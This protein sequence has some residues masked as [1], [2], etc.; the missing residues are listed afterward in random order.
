MSAFQARYEG[1]C[2]VA[3]GRRIEVGDEVVYVDDELVHVECEGRALAATRPR[4]VC[5]ECFCEMPCLCIDEPVVTPAAVCPECRDG[6]CRN[7]TEMTLNE[8]D[9][10]VSC[11]CGH[12]GAR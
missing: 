5:T 2:A 3:C 4:E 9:A 10:W 1:R 8:L 11:S 7:C 6:K 12:G